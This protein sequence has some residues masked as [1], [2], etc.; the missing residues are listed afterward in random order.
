MVL[1]RYVLM[2]YVDK[3]HN[4]VAGRPFPDRLLKSHRRGPPPFTQHE[5][6]EFMGV[7]KSTSGAHDITNGELTSNKCVDSNSTIQAA[8]RNRVVA[9]IMRRTCE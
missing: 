9:R 1:Y 6:Q 3:S 7:L 2:L 8:V 5:C 4:E